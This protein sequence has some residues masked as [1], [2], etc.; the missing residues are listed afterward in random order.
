MNNGDRG[1]S[2]GAHEEGDANRVFVD[3]DRAGVVYDGGERDLGK[4]G[5]VGVDAVRDVGR[6]GV[7]DDGGA[8]DCMAPGNNFAFLRG[9]GESVGVDMSV[10]RLEFGVN[11]GFPIAD[12]VVGS[13]GVGGIVGVG[14]GSVVDGV[15]SVADGRFG[16]S[17]V[18]SGLGGGVDRSIGVGNVAHVKSAPFSL[19]DASKNENWRV[20]NASFG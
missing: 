12:G 19:C 16:F 5:G 6:A 11:R 14:V 1:N 7:V 20:A 18:N 3:V 15:G 9:K 10:P 2:R 17:D 4:A 13:A 8:S